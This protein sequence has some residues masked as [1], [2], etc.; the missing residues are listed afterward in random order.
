MLKTNINKTLLIKRLILVLLLVGGV[1]FSIANKIVKKY[2]FTSVFDVIQTYDSNTRLAD[3]VRLKQVKISLS[4]DDFEFIKEK[5]QTA[6]DRG[7]QINE[8]D[9]Y[10][11][12]ELKYDNNE[13]KGEIRLKGHMTDHLEGDKWSFRVKVKDT[14]LGMYRFSLQHPG[15][16]NYVYEW[17]YHELLN[18]EGIINLYYDFVNL[19]LNNKDLGIYA[20]EEHFGQHVLE[21]NNRP[22]GAIIR[23]NPN[24]YWEGRID[25]YHKIYLSEEYSDYQ[26]SFAE[27]Y[28]KG[29]VINDEEL[30]E[31]YGIAAGRLELFRTGELKTSDVFDVQKMA[32]FL[33]VIDLVGGHHSLDWSDVKFYYN[34]ETKKVEPVGYESFSIRETNSIAGQINPEKYDGIELTYYAQLFSDPIFYESYIKNLERIADEGYLNK[35]YSKIETKFNEKI[36]IIAKEWPYRKFNFDGYFKNIRLIRHNLELPKPFHAFT[37]I[38]NKDSILIS[39]APVS[40]F[41]IQI[42]G[43]KVKDK[44]FLQESTF[45]L[46]P[47]ARQM[48]LSYYDF[49]LKGDFSKIKNIVILAKIP[50]SNNVFEVELAEYP[51]YKV[52]CEYVDTCDKLVGYDTTIFTLVD[53]VF[54]FI[55][56]TTIIRTKTIIPSGYQLVISPNQKILIEDELIVNGDIQIHG[57]KDFPVDFKTVK[58]GI[59][60]VYGSLKS[61]N[62]NFSGENC[63]YSNNAN[64]YFY[65]C[66]F[67]DINEVFITSFQSD[68][69]FKKCFSG[70]VKKLA[71]NNETN[72]LIENCTFKKWRCFVN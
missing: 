51:K 42:V 64:L 59:C 14:V 9:N 70:N 44:L 24:L 72:T 43:L 4:E 41:P 53:S 17:V 56:D 8:G 1:C 11:D 25:G 2:G 32:K 13:V 61:S 23:W 37:Q 62:T 5:R 26:S 38:H 15:T 27:P 29:N 18:H 65:H 12:C 33:A 60:K 7:L 19:E 57:L 54:K 35:F 55:N 45:I 39:L 31:N 36:G 28:D 30:L 48:A 69:V 66:L 6:L 67:Y 16:R 46:K 47:K 58:N 3:N 52:M 34:S 68:L 50:G 21:R 20:V 10:V 22:K 71:I 49:T 63:F 40:D